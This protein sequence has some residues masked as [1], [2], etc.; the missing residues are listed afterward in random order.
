MSYAERRFRAARLEFGHGTLSA[1]DEAAWLLTSVLGL[2]HEGLA[3]S[4]ARELTAR[5]RSSVSRLIEERVRGRRP[6]AYLLKEAWLGEHRFYVDGRVIVPRSF[7]AELLRD[8]LEPWISRPARVRRALDLC[9]G[10]GCLAILLALA[11]PRATLDATDVSRAALAVARRNLRA[12]RLG[13][14]VRLVRTDL[15]AGLEPARYDLVVANPPYVGAAAMR[16]LPLEYRREPRL[17]LDGGRDGLEFTRRIVLAARNF[18]RPRG[19]LVVE[20]GRNRGKLE[21]A[22]PR[23]PFIWPETSAGYDC[24]FVLNR[25]DLTESALQ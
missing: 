23:L 8:R 17:A 12:Y 21:R 9:T 4:L 20:I 16:R 15:F 24:V 13:E 7:I 5:E 22:F 11:F 1:R 19:L 14:R 3:Q 6:L 18:L 25:E 2:P 10:S